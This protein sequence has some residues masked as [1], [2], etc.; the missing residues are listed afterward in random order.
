M[1]NIL[2]ITILHIEFY[3][4]SYTNARHVFICDLTYYN[5]LLYE[6]KIT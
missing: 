3:I 4:F 2:Y 1:H 5:F 6:Y